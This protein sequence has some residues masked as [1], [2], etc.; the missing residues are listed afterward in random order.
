LNRYLFIQY[1]NLLDILPIG[2]PLLSVVQDHYNQDFYTI[3]LQL[4]SPYLNS[5]QQVLDIGCGVGRSVYELAKNCKLVYGVEFSFSSALIGR[6]M[7]RHFPNR[8]DECCLKLE[9]EIYEHKALGVW[10]GNNVEVI[11]ASGENLPFPSASVD[12]VNSWNVIDRVR[13]PKKMLMEKVRTLKPE[14]IFSIADPYS[15]GTETTPQENWMGGKENI[16]SADAIR[17]WIQQGLDIL[18]EEQ[19]IPWFLWMH[20]RNL[21]LFVNHCLIARKRYANKTEGA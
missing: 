15:W 3:A 12:V 6:R 14:G 8:L 10:Y 19:H 20:E 5:T 11:V 9:G 1:G 7:L 4:L 17:E 16:H 13:N 21:S 18:K 2:H